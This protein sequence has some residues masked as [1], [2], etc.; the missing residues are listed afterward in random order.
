MWLFSGKGFIS[1][2]ENRQ[3]R[4]RKTLLVRSRFREDLEQ[5][6]EMLDSSPVIQET[7]ER[8]YLYRI[9]VPR[10]DL[11]AVVQRIVT[12]IDY[13]NFKASVHGDPVRDRAYGRC[14]SAMYDAQS[15]AAPR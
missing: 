12:S 3:D 1:V 8:D 7:P 6:V 5:F 9:V 10:E 4:S 11:A 13:G 14:W 2:V 15:T